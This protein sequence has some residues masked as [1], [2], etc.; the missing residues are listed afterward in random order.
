MQAV[1]EP[2]KPQWHAIRPHVAGWFHLALLI[3]YLI[4]VA[5]RHRDMESWL[6]HHGFSGPLVKWLVLGAPLLLYG[7]IYL[8]RHR[9]DTHDSAIGS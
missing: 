6:A 5:R 2:A 9:Q 3:V 4:E 1:V 7:L 8:S